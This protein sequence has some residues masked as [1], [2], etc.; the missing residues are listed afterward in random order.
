MHIVITGANR[1]IGL[2]FTQQYLAQGHSVTAVCRTAS[3]ALKSSGASVIDGV[4]VTEAGGVAKLQAEL[5]GKHIDILINNAGLL[6]GDRL[7]ELPWA[8]I[9]RQFAVNTLGPLRVTEA[10]LGNLNSGSKVALI[11]SRMGSVA[12]NGSGNNYG[13]RMSKSALNIAGKSMAIDLK[14]KGVAVALLHPGFVQTEMVNNNGDITADEAASRL[15]KRIDEL[16]LE[17]TGCFRHSNG[18]DLPW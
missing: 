14:P 6:V 10:L 1:G 8:D 13:Y 5:A 12:D 3:E 16:S 15:I 7:G 17:T 18:E 2:A 11:T 4:D 9:E